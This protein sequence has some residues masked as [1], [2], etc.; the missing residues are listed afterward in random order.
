[1]SGFR[2]IHGPAVTQRKVVGRDIVWSKNILLQFCSQR[3][4]KP[5]ERWLG[6]VPS[7]RKV[8][9]TQP[10]SNESVIPP[11]ASGRTADE[12][13]RGGSAARRIEKNARET[14]HGTQ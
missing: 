7:G 3:I 6:V 5:D 12:A 1:M 14:P 11:Q 13:A 4:T 8:N 9:R 2:G 10:L